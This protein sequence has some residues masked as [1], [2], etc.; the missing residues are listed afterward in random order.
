MQSADLMMS[1][2]SALSC[3]WAKL[4]MVYFGINVEY[5]KFYV[6]TA[7]TDG[8]SLSHV[9]QIMVSNGMNR[10]FILLCFQG[11]SIAHTHSEQSAHPFRTVGNIAITPI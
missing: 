6:S 2:L 3:I 7:M 8:T 10:T 5:T 9:S 4:C 1:C 11:I